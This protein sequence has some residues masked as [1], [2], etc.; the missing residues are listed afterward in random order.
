VSV[1]RTLFALASAFVLVSQSCAPSRGA[2][3][4]DARVA[5]SSPAAPASA[6]TRLEP[7]AVD[8]ALSAAWK[9]ENVTPSAR[10]DDA[11]FLRRAYLDVVGTIPERAVVESFLADPSPQKRAKLVDDLLASPS[12]ADYWAAYWDDLLMGPR[13]QNPSVDRA[14]F[15]A[16]LRHAFE[17]NLPYDKLVYALVSATGQNSEG[18]PRNGGY[19]EAAGASAT[20][21]AA[22]GVANGA[23]NWILKYADTPQDLAGS[24]SRTF[25]GVQIQCA[26]CHDHKTEKWKQEDFQRFT[27]C[28]AHTRLEPIDAKAMGGQVRRV[29]VED[30]PRSPARFL[31]NADLKAILEARPAALD[32][33]DFSSTRDARAAVAAWMTSPRNPWFAQAIVNRVWGHF[34]GRGFVD[35][36]DDLRPSN[37]PEMPDLLQAIADDFVAGGYDL[38]RLVRLVTATDVYQ[39]AAAP[40]GEI[41]LWSRFRLSPLGPGELLSALMTA[42]KLDRTIA[43]IPRM[44]LDRIRAQLSRQYAFL[45]DVDEELDRASFEGTLAQTLTLLNGSATGTGS[46]ALPG[47]IVAEVVNGSGGREEKIQA[48]YVQVLSRRASPEELTYW[49]RYVGESEP[50]AAAAS[51]AP[52]GPGDPLRR[53]EARDARHRADARTAA[54]EDLV[55]ALL[56]SS[57]FAFN[58]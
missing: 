34:L 35:P 28:F 43:Q 54:Y 14:A 8:A 31:K 48:I 47:G 16:W 38:K 44:D 7:G 19:A 15:R 56:N 36:V 18:G 57:E 37:P 49:K 50:G 23:V 17:E 55:W 39:L 5:A 21:A 10:A 33:T 1:F 58:H 20:P 25:L 3:T 26:Q 42:T 27:A 40:G 53:L 9:K 12:Y 13:V 4:P 6:V 52:A 30:I 51:A 24:A 41:K 2:S 22:G 46:S 45:F 11:T 29:V 32:G